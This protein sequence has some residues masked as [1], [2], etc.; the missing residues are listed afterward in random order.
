M[1][2]WQAADKCEDKIEISLSRAMQNIELF[3]YETH[4]GTELLLENKYI[5]CNWWNLKEMTLILYTLLHT[6][7]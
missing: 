7:W 4:W 6:A 3:G 1:T 2:M 5:P